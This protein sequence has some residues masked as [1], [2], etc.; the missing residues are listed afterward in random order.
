MELF[1]RLKDKTVFTMFLK[2]H[3]KESCNVAPP[4][5]VYC[6]GG[7]NTRSALQPILYHTAEGRGL[8]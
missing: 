6:N 8:P 1:E 7:G 2:R 4:P 3:L 5:S